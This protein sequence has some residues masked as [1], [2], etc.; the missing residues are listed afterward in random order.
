MGNHRKHEKHGKPWEITGNMGNMGNH[1]KSREMPGYFSSFSYRA[2]A[3]VNSSRIKRTLFNLALRRKT[4]E[5][6]IGL[7]RNDS[8]WD[9]V[10]DFVVILFLQMQNS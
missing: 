6:N 4:K 8:F 9:K 5:I 10:L 2:V 7:L 1:G 3:S